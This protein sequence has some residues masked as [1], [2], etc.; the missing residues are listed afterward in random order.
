MK[1]WRTAPISATCQVLL[2]VSP[3]RFCGQPTT[4]A[5]PAMGYGWMALCEQHAIKHLPD[6]WPLQKLLA[7]GET[8][9]P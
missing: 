5:Y 8:L 9:K 1:N 4:H 6:C 3:D 2:F 7:E